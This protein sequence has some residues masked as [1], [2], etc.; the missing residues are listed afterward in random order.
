[1]KTIKEFRQSGLELSEYI[2]EPCE[3]DNELSR[4]LCG[5]HGANGR[6]LYNDMSITQPLIK[7][8][9]E[10]TKLLPTT[11]MDHNDNHRNYYIGS[12]GD[13]HIKDLTKNDEFLN[14]L[15]ELNLHRK[16]VD[17]SIDLLKD[18]K[19]FNELVDLKIEMFFDFH[20]DS[21]YFNEEISDEDL[22]KEID[23]DLD[24]TIYIVSKCAYN[25]FNKLYIDKNILSPDSIYDLIR[26]YIIS[27]IISQNKSSIKSDKRK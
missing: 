1:M 6:I 11:L 20:S 21:K 27:L 4:L 23:E 10:K 9:K 18:N 22:Y 8:E 2:S 14:V 13:I 7:D 12:F 5:Q 26:D 15:K 19:T 24:D 16:H 25:E 17:F 3:L